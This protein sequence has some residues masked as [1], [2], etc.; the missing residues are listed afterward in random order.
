MTPTQ[1]LAEARATEA[2]RDALY[3]A[4]T[5]LWARLTARGRHAGGPEAWARYWTLQAEYERL[6]EE[7]QA[8]LLGVAGEDPTDPYPLCPA[9]EGAGFIIRWRD[10]GDDSP[11][12]CPTC[13]GVGTLEPQEARDE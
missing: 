13:G 12:P 10:Y 4:L 3:A 6:N 5:P 7:L 1:T 8:R 11:D 2:R 9:C